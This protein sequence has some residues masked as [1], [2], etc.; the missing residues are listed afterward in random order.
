M[1][2]PPFALAPVSVHA[3]ELAHAKLSASGSHMWLV[4]TA[5]AWASAQFPDASSEYADEGTRA[6]AIGSEC[7]EQD[8]DVQQWCNDRFGCDP[9]DLA[10]HDP[11]NAEQYP[12]EMFECMQE[13]VDFVHEEITKALLRNP[14]AII[15]IEKRVDFSPWVREGF[16]TG[17]CII[18]SDG[19][20]RIIDYKH[21]KGVFV[22]V[23]DNEQLMLYGLGGWNMFHH[24]FDIKRIELTIYQPRVGNIKTW[25]VTVDQLVNWAEYHVKPIAERVWH[26]M[27]TGDLS[28]V[29]FNPKD[30]EV[31]RFCNARNHC[32]ARADEALAMAKYM[33]E[34][35]LMSAEEVATLLPRMAT[36]KKWANDLTTWAQAEAVKGKKFDGHKLVEGRSN[37]RYSDEG[38]VKTVLLLEGFN[39]P[40]I[41]KPRKL[42]GVTDMTKLLKG[43]KTFESLLGSHVM[44]PPGKPV[45]VEASDPRPELV[46]AVDAAS[47]GFEPVNL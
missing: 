5:S 10:E 26:A 2:T 6:H 39:E 11:V 1:T 38:A 46:E 18:I 44:K 34:D 8:I 40:Q 16:G 19:V 37:R 36:L 35:A 32:R 42:L 17:D 45:L 15:F 22:E 9:E 27:E 28:D 7:L 4:C 47:Q 13:Y 33:K 20:I 21:G 25:D 14:D 30:V 29:E 23:T 24:M 3:I 43:K 41:H 31:C 12:M